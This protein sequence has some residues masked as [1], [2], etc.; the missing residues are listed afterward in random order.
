MRTRALLGVAFVLL[1]SFAGSSFAAEPWAQ[2]AGK[3]CK[4]ASQVSPAAAPAVVKAEALKEAIFAAGWTCSTNAD[5]PCAAP[6]CYCITSLHRCICNLDL[7][8]VD[9]ECP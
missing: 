6:L 7:C 8:C 3:E 2:P 1:F 4:Q 9:G 5:C